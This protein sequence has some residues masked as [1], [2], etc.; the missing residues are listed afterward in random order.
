ML[1]DLLFLPQS[2]EDRY[3][4]KSQFLRESPCSSFLA[5]IVLLAGLDRFG[6]IE[7]KQQND[8]NEYDRHCALGFLSHR[9][10]I[11]AARSPSKTPSN[12][13]ERANQ[14]E[15]FQPESGAIAFVFILFSQAFE[16]R[17]FR[18]REIILACLGPRTQRD[19]SAPC[20]F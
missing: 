17:H 19:N 14:N 3:F 2:F 16:D 9:Q 13:L 18:K 7:T 15:T 8:Q 10:K 20:V 5:V 11:A 4:R 12:G 1:F 6:R